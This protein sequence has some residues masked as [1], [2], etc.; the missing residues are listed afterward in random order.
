MSPAELFTAP[1]PLHLALAAAALLVL[2]GGAG[3][4]WAWRRLG[5]RLA[6]LETAAAE[7][8]EAVGALCAGAAGTDRRMLGLEQGL[9]RLA[10]RQDRMELVH[11][12]ERAYD[13]AIRLVRNGAGLERLVA[14]CGLTAGEARLILML[15]GR[16]GGKAATASPTRAARAS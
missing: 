3:L 2:V 13:H 16:G 6:T 15:H 14:E 7:L 12:G 8:R 9:R 5:R 10:E 11:A 4:V 1:E